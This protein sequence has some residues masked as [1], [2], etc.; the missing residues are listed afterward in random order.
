[1]AVERWWERRQTREQ[2]TGR[3]KSRRGEFDGRRGLLLRET[4][5]KNSVQ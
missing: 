2:L 1:V 4:V 5:K 3:K